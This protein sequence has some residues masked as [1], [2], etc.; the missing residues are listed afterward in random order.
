M[1]M[2]LGRRHE[3]VSG[4]RGTSPSVGKV[5]QSRAPVLFLH[6][7]G[8][9]PRYW[10]RNECSKEGSVSFKSPF[11]WMG[12]NHRAARRHANSNR[13]RSII[14]LFVD[15]D[16]VVARVDETLDDE[17]G[18]SAPLAALVSAHVL[19]GVLDGRLADG[20]SPA[21]STLLATRAQLI[22][23]PTR[24]QVL[25]ESWLSLLEKARRPSP[26]L[27]SLEV[28]VVRTRVLG[29]ESQIRALAMALL[30][31]MVTPR[32]VA[33]ASSLLTDGSGPIY[34]GDSPS[35]L[36]SKLQDVITRLNPLTP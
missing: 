31:P 11:H 17:P 23:S 35:D 26:P 36:S 30:A 2:L 32:G 22:V 13:R 24:R 28:P 8:T 4:A 10:N 34:Y 18:V 21:S 7:F 1:P 20:K 33:M 5:E 27:Q 29:A 3:G 25:A 12:R 6:D 14:E 9:L 16:V 19:G 15:E